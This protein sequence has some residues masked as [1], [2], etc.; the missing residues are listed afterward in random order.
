MHLDWGLIGDVLWCMEVGVRIS[1]VMNAVCPV[2]HSRMRILVGSGQSRVMAGARVG[3]RQSPVAEVECSHVLT[4]VVGSCRIQGV[5]GTIYSSMGNACACPRVGLT[6]S[7]AGRLTS[8]R[9]RV[10]AIRL[11]LLGVHPC[12]MLAARTRRSCV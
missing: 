7:A 3:R 9:L 2:R 8:L 1:R 6:W 11:H 5:A 4:H 12:E 10:L